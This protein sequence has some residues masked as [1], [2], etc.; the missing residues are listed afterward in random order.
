[1]CH[2]S[3]RSGQEFCRQCGYR[4]GYYKREWVIGRDGKARQIK[5]FIMDLV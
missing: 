5:K 2:K 4:L 1:M 3:A